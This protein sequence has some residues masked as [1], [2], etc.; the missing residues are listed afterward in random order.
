MKMRRWIETMSR[1][2]FG[3]FVL[4]LALP[5]LSGCN[6][7]EK[8]QTATHTPHLMHEGVKLRGIGHSPATTPPTSVTYPRD[9][10]LKIRELELAHQERLAAIEAEKAKALKAL[11]LEKLRSVEELRQRTAE[12]EAANALKLEREKQKYAAIIAEKE[13]ALKALE[14]NA[15]LHR[16][17]TQRQITRLT[18]ETETKVATITGRFQEQIARLNKE[19]GEKTL[20]VVAGLLLLLLLAAFLF[21]RYR[22]QLETKAR[23]EERRHEAMMEASRQQHERLGKILDIIASDR[24]DNT[25]KL[26]LT[27]L[28]QQGTN[29]D[30]PRLLEYRPEE[31]AESEEPEEEAEEPRAG[32]EE[33]KA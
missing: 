17:E 7:N 23:E 3:I 12:I 15:S 25:V 22:K 19:L 8:R 14:A 21:Y 9:P 18:T 28:L 29:P 13:K 16:D 33:P 26:E 10:E 32:N 4:L 27:R 24:T 2:R 30:D 6:P 31:D 11:E 20:W 5:F 1:K